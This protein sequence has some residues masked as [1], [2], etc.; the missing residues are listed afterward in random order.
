MLCIPSARQ[1]GSRLVYWT[2][3]LD[4]S[5]HDTLQQNIPSPSSVRYEKRSLFLALTIPSTHWTSR[6]S[7]LTLEKILNNWLLLTFFMTLKMLQTSATFCLWHEVE[8]S[9]DVWK[10]R[11][12]GW[13]CRM[14][15]ISM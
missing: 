2:S 14:R 4:F 11:G 7:V 12:L 3:M 13:E 10:T 6:S 1:P 15:R 5:I 8:R 9:Q